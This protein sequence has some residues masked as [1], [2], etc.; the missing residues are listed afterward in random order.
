ME[1]TALKPIVNGSANLHLTVEDFADVEFA[2]QKHYIWCLIVSMQFANSFKD[3]DHKVFEPFISP[4]KFDDIT[5]ENVLELFP[6]IRKEYKDLENRMLAKTA[7]HRHE[8]G[9]RIYQAQAELGFG[10]MVEM[11]FDRT[12]GYISACGNWNDFKASDICHAIRT[13]EAIIPRQDYGPNNPNTGHKIHKWSTKHGCEYVVLDF[14]FV[15]RETAD[16]VNKFYSEHFKP[17]G[18]FIKADSIRI[19]ETECGHGYWKLELIWWWD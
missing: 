8:L 19:E 5:E 16:R 6:K 1:K 9:R 2:T 4:T 3:V 18:R 15:N 11:D 10:G 17:K 12:L 14:D 7:N 13:L